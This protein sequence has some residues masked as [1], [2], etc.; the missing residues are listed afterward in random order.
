MMMALQQIAITAALTSVSDCDGDAGL[1]AANS[2]QLSGFQAQG[3]KQAAPDA[4]V[5]NMAMSRVALRPFATAR[6]SIS[7]AAVR[8]LPCVSGFRPLRSGLL[9]SKRTTSRLQAAQE[10]IIEVNSL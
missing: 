1:S 6:G 7:I 3:N 8:R 2:P 9:A 4:S 10:P 5:I